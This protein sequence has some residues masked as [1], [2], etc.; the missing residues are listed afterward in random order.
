MFVVVYRPGSQPVRDQFFTELTL[1]LE[2]LAV[3][4][5]DVVLTGDFNIHVD[6]ASDLHAWRLGDVLQSFGLDQSVVGPTHVGGRTLDLVI[7]R[8]DRPRPTVVV[9]LPQVSD[10]SLVRFQL[11][12]QRPQLQYVDVETCTWKG[13]D[14]ERFRSDLLGS[15]A[16]CRALLAAT[17]AC[18]LMG[19]R[20]S[21][22]PDSAADR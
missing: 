12:L 6:D 17:L 10:H 16:C 5:C 19:Y 8:S 7:T 4:S 3:Y 9:D 20:S 13:F 1:V 18:Q 21:T 15:R 11:P 2:A 22:T 14:A